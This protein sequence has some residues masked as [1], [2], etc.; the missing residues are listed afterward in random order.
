MQE[1]LQSKKNE[2][3]QYEL[4]KMSGAA[5]EQTFKVSCSTIIANEFCIG[6]GIT[7][8]RAEQAA[9]EKMLIVIKN[10]NK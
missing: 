9:A 10:Q 4:V 5:H 7:R 2:L 3:P 1:L 8:K 6:T